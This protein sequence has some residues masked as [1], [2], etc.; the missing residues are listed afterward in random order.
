ML[1]NL[2]PALGYQRAEVIS[3]TRILWQRTGSAILPRLPAS[4]ELAKEL[5]SMEIN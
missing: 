2:H 1:E 5:L 3:D 4:A